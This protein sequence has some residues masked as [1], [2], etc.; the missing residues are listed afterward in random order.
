M[1]YWAAAILVITAWSSA[2]A[3][4][5]TVGVYGTAIVHMPAYP[6]EALARLMEGHVELEALFD[7]SGKIA[8][9]TPQGKSAGPINDIMRDESAKFIADLPFWGSPIKTGMHS[10]KVIV[11]YEISR[12]AP[13]GLESVSVFHPDPQRIVVSAAPPC[14]TASLEAN[15]RKV[16][17]A[18]MPSYPMI[19]RQA[20]IG[21]TVALT[22]QIS[23]AGDV[24]SV[25]V[26]SGHPMLVFAVKAAILNWKFEPA[27]A[28]SSF[29]V[30]VDFALDESGGITWSNTNPFVI[31]IYAVAPTVETE[32]NSI[33]EISSE[34]IRNPKI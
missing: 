22:L 24:S 4:E 11:D 9:V 13:C 15:Q 25:Q 1:I 32:T 19:A 12:G 23:P 30:T 7:P 29:N 16:I 28:E 3:Q 21:G 8:S 2:E 10:E 34:S 18:E 14:D 20:R 33:A 31:R 17:S 26:K 6:P 5:Q 27:K